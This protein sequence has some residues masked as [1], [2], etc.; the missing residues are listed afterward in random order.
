MMIEFKIITRQEYEELKKEILSLFNFVRVRRNKQKY[1][2]GGF[3][4]TPK[5]YENGF[6]SEQIDKI[7]EYLKNLKIDTEQLDILKDEVYSEDK[8][9][10][11]GTKIN[12]LVFKDGFDFLK[13][14]K[15]IEK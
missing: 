8:E 12:H 2:F 6:N 5:D 13:K 14:I 7:S 9:E 3:N 10:F 4:I 1:A 11:A 15:R